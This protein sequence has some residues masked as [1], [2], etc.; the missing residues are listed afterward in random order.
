MGKATYGELNVVQF[1]NSHCLKIGDFVSIAQEVVFLLDSEHY[2][3]HL[4]TFP[5]KVKYLGVEKE[6]A[7]GKGDIIVD[8]DVWL[9]FRST[10]MSGVHIGQGAIVAAG[11]LVTKDV[12]PY[13]IVGGYRH[14]L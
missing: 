5:F 10:I 9:G 6:E 3:K 1:A 12:P 4:S 2:T 14:K 8:D 7:F 11:S 13:A